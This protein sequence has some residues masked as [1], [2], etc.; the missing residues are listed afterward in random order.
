MFNTYLKQLFALLFIFT[1]LL[2]VFST[3]EVGSQQ[4]KYFFLLTNSVSVMT[5][6][7][8]VLV[9]NCH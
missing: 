8:N 7:S 9:E 4:L 6:Q 1:S 3:C 5:R 2:A